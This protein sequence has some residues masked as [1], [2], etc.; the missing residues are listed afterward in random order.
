LQYRL[1]NPVHAGV[2]RQICLQAPHNVVVIPKGGYMT[3]GNF[4]EKALPQEWPIFLPALL[5]VV[6]VLEIAPG[7]RR[8]CLFYEFPIVL[9]EDEPSPQVRQ[10]IEVSGWVC[11]V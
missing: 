6:D 11:L 5:A 9:S 4:S 10:K 2:S 8:N 3:C 1:G 7:G